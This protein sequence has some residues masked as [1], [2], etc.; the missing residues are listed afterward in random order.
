MGPVVC[1]E[2]LD[3]LVI[4]H[5]EQ[6]LMPQT[7]WTAGLLDEVKNSISEGYNLCDG[8]VL[9]MAVVEKL[10]GNGEND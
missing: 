3:E 5:R 6:R 9:R 10:V 7:Y 4:W 2:A 1:K 8:I